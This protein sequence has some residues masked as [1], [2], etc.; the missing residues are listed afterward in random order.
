M[1]YSS[2]VNPARAKIAADGLPPLASSVASAFSSL[3]SETLRSLLL[4][5]KSGGSCCRA[6]IARCAVTRGS[7]NFTRKT[8]STSISTPAGARPG[9]LALLLLLLL[10]FA[11]LACAEA[12]EAQ[13]RTIVRAAAE[14]AKVVRIRWM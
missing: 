1:T 5:A 13:A 8:P 10:L 6:A 4:R 3:F 14:H 12:F 11:L 7:L 9:L 2:L